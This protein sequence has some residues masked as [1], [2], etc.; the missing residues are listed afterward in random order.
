MDFNIC[1]AVGVIVEDGDTPMV[2]VYLLH[3]GVH[4]DNTITESLQLWCRREGDSAG[5]KIIINN[6]V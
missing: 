5:G 3:R 1:G 6:R 4:I 2:C